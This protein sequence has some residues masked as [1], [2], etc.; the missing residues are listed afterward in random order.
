MCFKYSN[1]YMSVPTYWLDKCF[2]MII[3]SGCINP[4][5]LKKELLWLSWFPTNGF[6]AYVFVL[7]IAAFS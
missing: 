3:K 6:F 5:T 4:P 7:Q 2:F 1:V